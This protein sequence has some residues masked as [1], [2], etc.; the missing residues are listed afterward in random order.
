MLTSNLTDQVSLSH[1]HPLAHNKLPKLLGKFQQIRMQ[2]VL[3]KEMLILSL[4]HIHNPL[5]GTQHC[6]TYLRWLTVVQWVPASPRQ[7][8]VLGR[9]RGQHVVYPPAPQPVQLRQVGWTGVVW[10]GRREGGKVAGWSVWQMHLCIV[11][12]TYDYCDES[13]LIVQGFLWGARGDILK[14]IAPLLSFL[15]YSHMCFSFY[16][17]TPPPPQDF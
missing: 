5:H 17:P 14:K 12:H 16:P 2:T 15:I 11:D 10:R 8:P 7:L 1:T 6:D 4:G 13:T 9:C 3:V